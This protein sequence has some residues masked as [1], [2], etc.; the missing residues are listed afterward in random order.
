MKARSAAAAPAA[1]E[2]AT[3][4]LENEIIAAAEAAPAVTPEA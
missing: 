3:V 1:A 2:K 4:A